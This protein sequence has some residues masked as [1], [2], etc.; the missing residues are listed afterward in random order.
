M[1]PILD[2]YEYNP[3]NIKGWN[4]ETGVLTF[5]GH[6]KTKTTETV[7]I[8]IVP[9]QHHDVELQKLQA[10]E[11]AGVI[12]IVETF[13]SDSYLYLIFAK[14][15]EKNPEETNATNKTNM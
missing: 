7:F 2:K 5:K 14:A 12:K 6:C 10:Q 4:S 1:L 3:K 15:G 11:K 9:I 13:K 8:K